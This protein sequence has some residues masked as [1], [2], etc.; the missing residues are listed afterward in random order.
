[1]FWTLETQLTIQGCSY[2]KDSLG[3][4]YSFS[5]SLPARML[6]MYKELVGYVTETG[7][8]NWPKGY[9]TPCS[10]MLS[11]QILR[12][13]EKEGDVWSGGVCWPK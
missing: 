6:G 11:I 12:K 9:S 13:K 1:M 8:A 10:V 2:H 3:L 4:C 5:H 7:D